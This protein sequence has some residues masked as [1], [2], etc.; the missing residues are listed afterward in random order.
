MT[1]TDA[2][3]DYVLLTLIVDRT[4]SKKTVKALSGQ[5]VYS[6]FA[7]PASGTAPSDM[8][9]LLGLGNTK[10][11]IILCTLR[12]SSAATVFRRLI[13]ECR[14]D[15]PGHGIAFT[16]PLTSIL[17]GRGFFDLGDFEYGGKDMN[18][19]TTAFRHDLILISV[20]SGFSDDAMSAARS[21]YPV[22]GTI[23]KGRETGLK[24]GEKFFGVEIQ[25][26]RE[27]VV[28]L[29]ERERTQDILHAIMDKAGPDSKADA[30]A[31]A[32]PVRD[33]AGLKTEK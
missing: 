29:T 8:L 5:G 17:Y 27:L 15:K 1:R 16:I 14:L 12:E 18:E 4:H 11:D 21:V 26:E 24:E 3:D 31:V 2:P 32:L 23:V 9:T 10:K 13:D 6:S 19:Q 7:M 22:G 28:I 33:T 25:P 30:F 20:K